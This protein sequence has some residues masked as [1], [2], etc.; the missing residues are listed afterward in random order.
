MIKLVERISVIPLI[1]TSYTGFTKSEK[2]VA[3]IVLKDPQSII[4]SSITDLSEHCEVGEATILRF[5]KKLG[6]NG[7]QSFKMTLAQ[8]L[9]KED[10]VDVQLSDEITKDDSIQ[11][12]CK[13]I[14]NTDICALNETFALIDYKSIE[15][16]V[17][18]LIKAKRIVFFGV[19]SSAITAQDA[20]NKFMRIT[21]NVEFSYDSHMQSMIASLMCDKEVAIAFS[22][23][24]STKDTIEM[25]KTA[26]KTGAK[27]VCV[28]RYGKSPITQYA[29]HVLL[30]GA[31][32]GPLQGGALSTK[33]AQLFI[34]D[35]LYAEY[36]RKNARISKFNK[37]KTAEAISDKLY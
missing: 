32:E 16:V 15:E 26:K 23:S 28:T 36:F 12:V 21:S 5:C 17:E 9:Q 13:K 31:K 8:S 30:I 27:T 33:I 18:W 2:K 34:I 14:L 29:D 37:E 4:Y 24:G 7:Y 3:D 6:F 1:N 20:K 22:Y 35:I 11:D 10:E 25:L 19:G